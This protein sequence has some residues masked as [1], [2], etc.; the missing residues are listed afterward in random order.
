MALINCKECGKEISNTAPV[1]PHCGNLLTPNYRKTELTS[2]V[3]GLDFYAMIVGVILQIFAVIIFFKFDP[4]YIDMRVG[5]GSDYNT[6]TYT[7]FA[8][9]AIA[10]RYGLSGIL[11]GIGTL[12]ECHRTR[13]YGIS[14]NT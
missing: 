10:L 13:Y 1:C 8:Y 7:T 11:F 3:S 12:L 5:F 4:E 14:Q 9:I 6:Y 2:D